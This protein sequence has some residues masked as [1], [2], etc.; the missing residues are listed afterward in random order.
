MRR[1]LVE[2]NIQVLISDKDLD[3]SRK[4]NKWRSETKVMRSKMFK[5]QFRFAY[6]DENLEIFR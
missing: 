4:L 6:D 1:I 3:I 2:L 5:N